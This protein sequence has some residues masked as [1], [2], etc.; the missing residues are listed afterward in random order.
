M[1]YLTARREA[2][3]EI[4]AHDVDVDDALAGGRLAVSAAAG[5]YLSGGFAPG[6]MVAVLRD[7]VDRAVADGYDGMYVIGEMSWAAFGDVPGAERLGEYET[8]VDEVCATRPV[9]TLCQYDRRDF[10][11]PRLTE[12]VG[13]HRRW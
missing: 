8:A 9:T 2:L 3:D 1:L 13:L 5:T 12:L 6:R 11:V 4:R 7:A 10:D